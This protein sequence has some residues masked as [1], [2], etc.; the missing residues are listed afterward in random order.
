MFLFPPT[1]WLFSEMASQLIW[2]SSV[3]MDLFYLECCCHCTKMFSKDQE[4][5]ELDN[6]VQLSQEKKGK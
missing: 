1:R 3:F 4:G 5:P 2:S 6:T